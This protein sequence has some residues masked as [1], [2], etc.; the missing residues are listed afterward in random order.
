MFRFNAAKLSTEGK[1]YVFTATDTLPD[2]MK[3]DLQYFNKNK[4]VFN[5]DG[6]NWFNAASAKARGIHVDMTEKTVSI[7]IPKSTD[8]FGKGQQVDTLDGKTLN[9]RLRAIVQDHVMRDK[10]IEFVE[11]TCD[12]KVTNLDWTI[13]DKDKNHK[14][15]IL[16]QGGW[17]SG[18]KPGELKVIKLL[19]GS[20][21][22]IKDVEFTLARK[23][24]T[25]IQIRQENGTYSS[26]GKTITLTTNSEGIADIKGLGLATYVLTESKVPGWIAFDVNH[27]VKKEFTVSGSD[28]EGQEYTI[29]NSKKYISIPVE[30]KWEGH[31]GQEVKIQLLADGKVKDQ[32]T[33][34][35]KNNEDTTWKHTFENLPQCTDEGKE[36][37]YDVKE[38]DPSG[39]VLE[40]GE[41]FQLDGKWFRVTVDGSV[42]DGFT[43]T[44]KAMPAWT[45]MTPPTRD[46][47]VEKKWQSYDGKE[48]SPPVDKIEV[49]LY[50]DGEATGNRKK[51]DES[52]H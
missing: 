43:I 2:S 17:A 20:K 41:E 34:Q 18:I 19:K 3:W 52:N 26:K 13:T 23:D 21:K 33:L 31:T 45:P 28:V 48:I 40:N 47:Q 6:R 8:L 37:Q 49:E 10:S 27:P 7:S 51:L 15:K 4:Y 30:K 22:P 24:G 38:I 50:K 44:N 25:D 46:I 42:K 16:R 39:N 11:N 35:K 12:A 36:I 5:V 1:D 29:E 32:V 14:V 9:I